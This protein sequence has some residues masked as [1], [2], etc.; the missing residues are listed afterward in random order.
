M[1]NFNGDNDEGNGS[2]SYEEAFELAGHGRYNYLVLVTCC[3]ISVAVAMDMFGFGV[4]VAAASCD[5]KLTIGQTGLLVGSPF[6]GLL[7]AYFWGYY[8]DTRGRRQALLVSTSVGFIFGALTSFAISWEMM[9]VTKII[10]SSFLMAS[11][12]I[13]ITY[14]GESTR[15][16]NRNQFI[17]IMVSMNLGAEVISFGLAYFI[18]PLTFAY[19]LFSL[20]IIFNSWRF[21]TFLLATPLG[22][23]AL[24]LCFLYESPKFL[25]EKSGDEAMNVLKKIFVFNGGDEVNFPVKSLHLS[26]N[27]QNKSFCSSLTTQASPLFT[28][29]LLWRTMQLF[30]L[31]AL[32]C[33]INNAFIMWFPTM[34]D[35]FFNSMFS[36]KDIEFSFCDSIRNVTVSEN[37]ENVE[38]LCTGVISGE[39][40]YSGVF[41]SLFFA[42]LNLVVAMFAKWRRLVLIS[43][44]A[45]SAVSCLVVVLQNQPIASVVFFTLIQITAIGLGSVSSYFV[46][47]YPTTCSG[48][49]TSLGF[50]FA[51][52]ASLT[53]VTV[54]GATIVGNCETIFYIYAA[55]GVSGIVVALLLPSDR[56]K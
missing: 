27:I 53:S 20:P 29:P 36:G 28:P 45:I 15:T 43:S 5:L 7:F 44:F 56:S 10:C 50:M 23:G 21:Y 35:I 34:V 3:I 52:F 33:S 18:L 22:L 48:L 31:L 38:K 11:Q 8:A 24:F 40:L 41:A 47:I 54:I 37:V 9:L 26:S 16:K 4:V 19:Q 12:T 30:F 55:L 13:I 46:D 32:V 51:R 42:V 25:A 49:A 1:A 14:L 2:W 17:F 6:T 39:T